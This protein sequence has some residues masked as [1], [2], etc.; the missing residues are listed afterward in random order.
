MAI[1]G[2]DLVLIVC[3]SKQALDLIKYLTCASPASLFKLSRVWKSFIPPLTI[4]IRASSLSGV[5]WNFLRFNTAPPSLIIRQSTIHADDGLL[6]PL[7]KTHQ[8]SNFPPKASAS[9]WESG[10]QKMERWAGAARV[11]S[12]SASATTASN[13]TYSVCVRLRCTGGVICRPMREPSLIR[14]QRRGFEAAWR[15]IVWNINESKGNGIN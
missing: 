11:R 12:S 4:F 10:V 2:N 5:L 8:K 3:N 7:I 14:D 6:A 15:Q 13:V 1:Y 9:T